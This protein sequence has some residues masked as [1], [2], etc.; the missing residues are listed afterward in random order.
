VIGGQSHSIY[1]TLPRFIEN[2]VLLG[3]NNLLPVDNAAVVR[4]LVIQGGA[5]MLGNPN[6]SA[7]AAP[8]LGSLLVSGSATQLNTPTGMKDAATIGWRK[9]A[10][11]TALFYRND[12]LMFGALPMEA[13]GTG[14]TSGEAK[15]IGDAGGDLTGYYP[16]P[17]IRDS[18]VSNAKMSN[19]PKWTIKGNGGNDYFPPQDLSVDETKALLVLDKVDNTSDAEKIISDATQ[20]ALDSEAAA[21]QAAD[22]ALQTAIYDKA[23]ANAS[24]SADT[25]TGT[26]ITTPAVQSATVASILQTI[27][28]KIRQVA[29]VA[30]GKQNAL[31]AGANIQISGST[32]SATNTVP[33]DATLTI[34]KNGANVATFTANASSNATANITVPTTDNTAPSALASGGT[35]SPGSSDLYARRDH[36]HTLPAYPDVSGKM[37][38]PNGTASQLVRG[39]GTLTQ[40]G[41]VASKI[42]TRNATSDPGS[43]NYSVNPDYDNILFY[44]TRNGNFRGY[45]FNATSTNTAEKLVNGMIRTFAAA[46]TGT[47]PIASD[48]LN[49]DEWLIFYRA[50]LYYSSTAAR[51]AY[52]WTKAM[53]YYNNTTYVPSYFGVNLVFCFRNAWQGQGNSAPMWAETCG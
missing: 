4:N 39:D 45:A 51:Q 21:R 24:L 26:D 18:A 42:D 33:N 16:N 30:N 25:G 48:I 10:N 6:D 41:Y 27:W 14:N 47:T 3:G 43:S 7:Y 40:N 49:D 20:A 8:S 46:H 53:I 31:T 2:S 50:A 23:P 36:S 1:N 35:G 11:D 44:T 17:I 32:I 29:N 13:G 19:M 15:P 52:R 12:D 28:A 37:D 34:Q 38:K 5:L 9:G 22:T